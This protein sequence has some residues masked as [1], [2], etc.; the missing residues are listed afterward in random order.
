M[1]LGSLSWVHSSEKI[2]LRQLRFYTD[3][4]EGFIAVIRKMLT[5]RVHI[6]FL[7]HT[8]SFQLGE[9]PNALSFKNS[10]NNPYGLHH[11]AQKACSDICWHSMMVQNIFSINNSNRIGLSLKQTGFWKLP[12]PGLLQVQSAA[13][14]H[15]GRRGSFHLKPES[16]INTK[17][18]GPMIRSNPF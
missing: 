8:R 2:N 13:E 9:I 7:F 4:L 11:R 17:V 12:T 15:L 16:L 5:S 3:W 1:C 6:I 10:Q 14:A 18:W